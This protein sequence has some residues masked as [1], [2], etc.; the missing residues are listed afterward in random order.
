MQNKLTFRDERAVPT[1]SRVFAGG[2]VATEQRFR[3]IVEEALGPVHRRLLGARGAAAAAA[4]RRLRRLV[5]GTEALAY[6]HRR[7]QLVDV[8]LGKGTSFWSQKP[9]NQKGV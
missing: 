9:K 5:T 7:H 6:I 2:G 4:A 8:K 3:L 1:K